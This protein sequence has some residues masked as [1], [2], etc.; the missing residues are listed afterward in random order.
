MA[1]NKSAESVLDVVPAHDESIFGSENFSNVDPEY[2]HSVNKVDEPADLSHVVDL[3]VPQQFLNGEI[4]AQRK[5]IN[6]A[7]KEGKDPQE[8]ADAEDEE[9]EKKDEEPSAPPAT[10]GTTTPGTP[11]QPNVPKPASQK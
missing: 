4:P 8:L 10:P 1:D 11:V 3:N 5:K 9:E 2:A 6:E 7:V